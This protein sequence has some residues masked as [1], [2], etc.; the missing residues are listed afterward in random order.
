MSPIVKLEP[1]A[2][3]V[4]Y[5]FTLENNEGIADFDWDGGESLEGP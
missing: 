5:F 1:T 3:D 4:D 2:G